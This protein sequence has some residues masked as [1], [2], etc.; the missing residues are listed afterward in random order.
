MIFFNRVHAFGTYFSISCTR[1]ANLSVRFKNYFVFTFVATGNVI[2]TMVFAVFELPLN[3]LITAFTK[4]VHRSILNIAQSLL[5]VLSN[6]KFCTILVL[7][8]PFLVITTP[9]RH[10]LFF[11]TL[12]T[13]YI[14]VE[15]FLQ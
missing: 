13:I 12:V 10:F 8:S 14:C 2:H 11:F 6:L 9:V 3:L 7:L 5:I 15:K 1:I 4:M